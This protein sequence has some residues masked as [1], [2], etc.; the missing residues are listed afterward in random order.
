MITA[1]HKFGWAKENELQPRLEGYFG[2][3]TKS[4]SRYSRF[5]FENENYLIELKC[6]QAPLLPET[7]SEWML[8]CCKVLNLEKQLVVFYYFEQDKS[9]WY[10]L[11]DE[12]MFKDFKVIRNYYGQRTFLIPR[13]CWT[14]LGSESEELEVFSESSE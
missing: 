10:I 9:L 6:R 7:Y 4:E 11:Y 1:L 13:S 5:D 2:T 3:L 12:D 8:P 14:K